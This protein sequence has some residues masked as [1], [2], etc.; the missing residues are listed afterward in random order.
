M[1][2]IDDLFRDGLSGRKA[3]IPNTNDLWARI[4]A[5]KQQPLPEGEAL[6]ATF[7]DKLRERSA[8]VPPNMWSRIAAARARRPWVRWV[9]GAAAVLLLF[10]VAGISLYRS[11]ESPTV[12]PPPASAATTPPI[13]QVPAGEG[14]LSDALTNGV[15]DN[16]PTTTGDAT[17]P[18]LTP[19]NPAENGNGTS[20]PNK[21]EV[22]ATPT[23]NN[24]TPTR[25][26][27]IPPVTSSDL[28]TLIED[29]VPA[30]NIAAPAIVTE[31]TGETAEL[32][33]PVALPTVTVTNSSPTFRSRGLSSLKTELLFGIAYARQEFG[34]QD[35]AAVALRDIRQSSEF[36]EFGYQITLRTTYQLNERFRLLAGLTYAEIRNELEYESFS[37]GQPTLVTTNNNIR[38]LEAPV[39]VGYSVP[40]RRVNVTVNAGP[41]INLTTSVRGRFLDPDFGS[42]QDL[43]T[44]GNYRNN[45]G[46]GFMASLSTAYQ[47]G[48]KRPVTIL[49]EPYFKTYPTAF[50]VTGAPVREK[51]WVAGLQLGI[52][53][54][55]R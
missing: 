50:T 2:H 4:N 33:L 32:D 34:L 40:G 37:G 47:I 24:P 13:A 7:R 31:L 39:L 51:Y 42:P 52:R 15:T 44:A 45:V 35:P 26:G 8:A 16:T 29:P 36:P 17:P 3:D 38:M 53:K 21:Q 54:S 20:S 18:P 23:D 14:V 30:R 10:L 12:A 55:L 19:S 48:K 49:L 1:S 46:I 41:L 25:D 28:S 5:A 6:D 11:G 43:A 9:L 27:D 22:L